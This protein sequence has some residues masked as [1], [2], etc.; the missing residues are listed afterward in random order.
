MIYRKYFL[1]FFLIV[2]IIFLQL[3][4]YFPS[5]IENYYSNGIFSYLSKI[6]RLLFGWIYFSV[7]DILYFFCLIYLLIQLFKI[8]NKKPISWSNYFLKIINKISV[9]YFV[10]HLMWGFNYYRI[11]LFEKMKINKEYSKSDLIY[12]TERLI[13]KTNEVH[14]EITKN[15]N[16]KVTIAFDNNNMFNIAQIGYKNVSNQYPFFTYSNPSQKESLFSKLLTDMGF[17]GYLNPITNEMQV[18]YLILKTYKPMVVCHEMAHQIGYASESECN[19]IGFLASS[20]SGNLFFQYSGYANALRYCLALIASED[21][22][23]F[24]QLVSKLNKG[25]LI[26]FKENEQFWKSYDSF[27]EKGFHAFYDQYLKINQQKDGISSYSKFIDLLINYY[28]NKV[29]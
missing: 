20:K 13:Q 15:E 4:S 9:I 17:S 10:F 27:I 24:N 19:F 18:N 11:P 14:F 6:E 25:I 7:G 23:L 1:S 8:K 2:Q 26:D 3:I 5:F 22:T 12:F 21:K 16:E 29:L 28:R